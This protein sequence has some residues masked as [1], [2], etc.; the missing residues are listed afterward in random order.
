M[1]ATNRTATAAA[2]AAS[3]APGIQPP[4]GPQGVEEEPGEQDRAR[5]SDPQWR[6]IDGGVGLGAAQTERR[7]VAGRR[8]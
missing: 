5:E 4:S 8:H 1:T 2:R 7:D 3:S 6:E